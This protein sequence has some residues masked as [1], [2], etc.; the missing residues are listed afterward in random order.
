[1]PYTRVRC[2]VP[3]AMVH[4]RV[5]MKGCSLVGSADGY[6]NRAKTPAGLVPRPCPTG[7]DMCVSRTNLLAREMSLC[8]H[9]FAR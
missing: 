3:G 9:V 6:R 5:A 2:R 4:A 7:G 8:R 1:M